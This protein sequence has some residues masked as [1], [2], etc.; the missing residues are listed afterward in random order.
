M[1]LSWVKSWYGLSCALQ[2]ELTWSGLCVPLQG[3]VLPKHPCQSTSWELSSFSWPTAFISNIYFRSQNSKDIERA[4]HEDG[5]LYASRV[6]KQKQDLG[7]KWGV[8][9]MHSSVKKRLGKDVCVSQD[10]GVGNKTCLVY[11][12][13]M[14]QTFYGKN[15]YYSTCTNSHSSLGIPVCFLS[16]FPHILLSATAFNPTRCQLPS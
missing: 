4:Q 14:R 2:K 13:N 11:L 3:L 10:I 9:R 12:A 5:S 7:Q 16:R 6:A 8:V 1:H 15:G